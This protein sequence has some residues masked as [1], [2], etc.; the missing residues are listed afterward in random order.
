MA[1]ARTRRHS[2]SEKKIPLAALQNPFE[3]EEALDEIDERGSTALPVTLFADMETD[4]DDYYDAR[5]TGL[6]ECI[7]NHLRDYQS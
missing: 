7:D 2:R 4:D 6:G 3:Q 5:M 1:H